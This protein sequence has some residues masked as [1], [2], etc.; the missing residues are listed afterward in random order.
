MKYVLSTS[1]IASALMLAISAGGAS[2]KSSVP[3]QRISFAV[4]GGN[5]EATGFIQNGRAMMPLRKLFS[6]IGL[7][8]DRVVWDGGD[9][10][11]RVY[12][13]GTEVVFRI[14]SDVITM[15]GISNKMNEKAVL[16]DGITYIP[17][18][19]LSQLYSYNVEWKGETNTVNVT[20]NQASKAKAVLE[21]L[22]SGN[23]QAVLDYISSETYIQ[24]NLNFS[25]GRD[26]LL[27]SLDTLKAAGTR[28]DVKRVITDGEYVALHTDYNVFGE[29]AGFDIFRFENGKIVEHW[30]NLQDKIA[31]NPSMHT[32]LDGAV[33]VTDLNKSDENKALVRQF[34]EDV[35]MGNNP[36]A[37]T[38]YFDGDQYIQHNPYIGDG[39]S[40]LGKALEE[41]AKQGITMQYDQIHMIVGQGNFVLVVSEGS[42]GGKHTSFYD[43]FRV[44]NGKIAEH[45][46]TLETIPDRTEWKNPNGKF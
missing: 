19:V 7:D 42:L 37:L 45:W 24:H 20:L 39:L 34:V 40:G 33:E 1:L 13:D 29:K 22:E 9:R 5:I 3:E 16:H 44:E 12:A 23:P 26:G 25:D 2:A 11:I 38:S 32:L 4:E 10:S 14:S 36:G 17:V 8:A 31:P 15:N 6:S 46:D 18:T 35:L 30:D 41:W 28:V 21:S 27:D 43:L